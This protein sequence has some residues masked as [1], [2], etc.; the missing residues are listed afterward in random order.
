MKLLDTELKLGNKEVKLL[1]TGSE[2][3]ETEVKLGDTE[4]KLGGT[5]DRL[6]DTE[7]QV[8]SLYID[9]WTNI[10]S[11]SYGSSALKK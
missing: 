8:H 5:K 4:V 1:D 7:V 10:Q 9:E 3:R 6:R 2:V 11:E